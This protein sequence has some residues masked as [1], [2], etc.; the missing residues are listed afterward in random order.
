MGW[1]CGFFAGGCTQ[2][3]VSDTGV[4]KEISSDSWKIQDEDGNVPKK[5]SE[6]VLYEVHVDVEDGSG[7]DLNGT[8]KEVTLSVV[9]GK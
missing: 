8:E 1:Q 6:D 7:Y 3:K 4:L 9:L 5:L 2:N